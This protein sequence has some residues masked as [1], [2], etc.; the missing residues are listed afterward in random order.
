MPTIK[1][2]LGGLNNCSDP[3]KQIVAIMVLTLELEFLKVLHDVQT[4]HQARD[5]EHLEAVGTPL[6]SVIKRQASVERLKGTSDLLRF[7]LVESRSWMR[8]GLKS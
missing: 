1:T 3:E 8:I 2:D 5:H 6:E 4:M 7:L